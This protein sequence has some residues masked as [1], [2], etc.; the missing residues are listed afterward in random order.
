M[1][2][3][4]GT[5][6]L[7]AA[8]SANDNAAK[9]A[10]NYIRAD[11]TGIRIANANPDTASTYQHQTAT[12]TEFVVNNVSM[13]EFGGSGA[14]IGK[15]YDANS[16]DN[17]SHMELDYHSMQ[18]IDKEGNPYFHVSD[19]RESDGYATQSEEFIGDGSTKNFAVNASVVEV[20][21]VTLNGNETTA[22]SRSFRTFT[23][24]TAPASGD[25]IVITY[26]SDDAMLK[27][28]TFGQRGAGNI[29]PYSVAEGYG[30]VASSQYSHAEGLNT[31]ASGYYS[32]AEGRYTKAGGTGS[33]A[34]G[35]S[36]VASG[37]C[38]HAEGDG[39]TAS[40]QRS[41][42]EG[43]GS[44]ASETGS[45]AEGGGS[46]ASGYYSHAEGYS[47]TASENY[48][49]AEGYR[50]TAS[51]HYS[52]AGGCGTTAGYAGQTAIG[53]YNDNKST[54]LFEIGN[55]TSSTP[56]NAFEVDSNGNVVASGTY[57]GGTVND[58]GW[59]TLTLSSG[60]SAYS[61]DATPK[62][63]KVNGM[64][65]VR[66]A[67]KPTSAKTLNATVQTFAT[68][69]EGYRPSGYDV[70][71]ICQASDTKIWLLSITTNGNVQASRLRVMNSTTYQSAGTSEWLV[72]QA[73]YFA[74]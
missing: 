18:L 57:N 14:R 49:H 16:N 51:G 68:L 35:W 39:T 70:D 31:I 38:S 40:G 66:G 22:Y 6:D 1:P 4:T 3:E 54:N 2:T 37:Y 5:I 74:G 27:A 55:G 64:V 9:Y 61:S 41:H 43:Y 29:G 56:S 50:T 62:Y 34:E 15:A 42:A 53:E 8:K 71:I 44:V 65:E 23:F 46:T 72:F 60:W 13:A 28:Y 32:H 10:D 69:P 25:E 36:P 45:H 47:T 20:L 52:H 30:T 19:L 26:K 67:V 7:K 48:S 12:N 17:E 11:A 24:D 21:S 58:S 73:S 63:R 59:Q 33:H